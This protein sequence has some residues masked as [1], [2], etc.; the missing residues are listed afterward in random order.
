MA[1]EPLRILA[2]GD[3][4]TAGYGLTP[5]DGFPSQLQRKLI[6]MGYSARVL[7]GGVS[8]DTSAGGLARLDWALSDRPTHAIVELG[9]NDGLRGLD[10]AAMRANLDAI[11]QR[12]QNAGIAV[13]FTGM[14]APPNLGRSYETSF[15]K[16]FPELAKKH[17]V[18]FY[19]FF[20]SGVAARPALNLA[21]GLHPN[22][23]G[24][25][26]IVDR[27]AP[28]VVRLLKDRKQG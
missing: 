28:F 2:L 15:N 22:R 13:L 21:D 14:R 27:I 23:D 9:A 6:A 11:I 24:V 8:G 20:L 1:A 7:N 12:L 17:N 10:P 4:L 18:V 19:P 5:E 26:A 3:S 16:V 25:A